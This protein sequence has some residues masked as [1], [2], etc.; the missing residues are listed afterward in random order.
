V[1]SSI[2]V[3]E[4]YEAFLNKE[5]IIPNYPLVIMGDRLI[6]EGVIV[7]EWIDG[8]LH[9]SQQRGGDSK[10]IVR[11]KNNILALA[12]KKEIEIEVE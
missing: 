2:L 3:V 11:H 9:I 4:V 1:R 5:Q 7:A 12:K 8:R 10:K 6:C